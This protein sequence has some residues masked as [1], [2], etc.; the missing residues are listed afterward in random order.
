MKIRIFTLCQNYENRTYIVLPEKSISL[1]WVQLKL[2]NA[3]QYEI[4]RSDNDKYS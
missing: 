3:K 2:I 1:C 4:K